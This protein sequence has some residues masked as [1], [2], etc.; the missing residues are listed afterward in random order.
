MYILGTCIAG[1]FCFSAVLVDQLLLN[2]EDT[3]ENK[4]IKNEIIFLF[5]GG[6]VSY[7]NVGK[8]SL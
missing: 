5:G 1:L 4:T 6:G 8:L 3:S 7:Q 2:M